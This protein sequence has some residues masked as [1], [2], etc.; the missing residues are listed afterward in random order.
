MLENRP[1]VFA[2]LTGAYGPNCLFGRFRKGLLRN[3]GHK[4]R[5]EALFLRDTGR[6]Y[7]LF[8]GSGF[9]GRTGLISTIPTLPISIVRGEICAPLE[10][11]PTVSVGEPG[12]T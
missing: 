6:F 5:A 1:L 11:P 7:C 3:F 10:G 4:K 2:I 12:P 9:S 8:F